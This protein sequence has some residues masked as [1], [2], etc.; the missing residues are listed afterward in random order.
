MHSALHM[1]YE[2][3]QTVYRS[4]GLSEK[5]GAPGKSG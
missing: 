1:Y 4:V 5:Q 2:D 3:V